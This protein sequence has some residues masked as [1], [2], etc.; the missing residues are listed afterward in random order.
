MHFILAQSMRANTGK[1]QPTLL[2]GRLFSKLS[3][4]INTKSKSSKLH[5][6]TKFK[7]WG[8]QAPFLSD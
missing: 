5:E 1:T 7:P 2:R 4:G 6:F 3:L 8:S